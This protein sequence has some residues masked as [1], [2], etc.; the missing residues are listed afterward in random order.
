[1]VGRDWHGTN[2][3]ER[4]FFKFNGL[5]GIFLLLKNHTRKI[6]R[7][8]FSCYVRH[9]KV[10]LETDYYLQTNKNNFT[11]QFKSLNSRSFFQDKIVLHLKQTFAEEE[12]SR[13]G[14]TFTSL[15]SCP[16]LLSNL[17]STPSLFKKNMLRLLLGKKRAIEWNLLLPFQKNN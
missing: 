3:C 4:F 9:M 6:I 10:K 14:L 5:L 12:A 17:W 16:R 2:F 15:L 11:V 13:D 1:L 8:Y 7:K